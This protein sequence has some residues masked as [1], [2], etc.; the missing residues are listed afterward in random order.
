MGAAPVALLSE[1]DDFEATIVLYFRLWAEG[2]SG[3]K[4]LLEEFDRLFGV[5]EGSNNV[6]YFDNLCATV[7]K[8]ARR[9]LLKQSLSCNCVGA[10][11]R[12]FAFMIVL[13]VDSSFE[14]CCL[15]AALIT[16]NEIAGEKVMLARKVGVLIEKTFNKEHIL[17]KSLGFESFAVN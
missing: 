13:A 11:E 1:M 10:D 6:Q 3:R 8:N 7:V 15:I 2:I 16:N 12:C 5:V 9:P 17:R 14:D 4:A